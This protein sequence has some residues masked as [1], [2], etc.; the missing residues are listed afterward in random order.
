M[1]FDVGSWNAWEALIPKM[2][3]RWVENE[4]R[5][6]CDR[7][8]KAMRETETMIMDQLH[9]EHQVSHE[10]RHDKIPVKIDLWRQLDHAGGP[11]AFSQGGAD[12]MEEPWYD[13]NRGKDEHGRR[14]TICGKCKKQV[15]GLNVLI[16]VYDCSGDRFGRVCKMCVR[17]GMGERTNWILVNAIARGSSS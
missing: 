4:R 12:A 7:Q 3:H 15:D 10:D 6:V 5:G 17:I 11:L 1:E 14:I 8:A 2:K 16:P 9:K 13:E